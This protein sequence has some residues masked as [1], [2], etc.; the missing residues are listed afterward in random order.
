MADQPLR[1]RGAS[2][3]DP[4]TEPVAPTGPA[5]GPGPSE[6]GPPASDAKHWSERLRVVGGLAAVVVGVIA[7]FG[8]AIGALIANSQ[9]AATIAGSTAGV[10]GSIV[11][12]YFGV[13][14]GTDQAEN[15]LERVEKESATKDKN[16]AKA[17]VYA[18]HVA[19]ADAHAVEAAAEE[20]AGAI[21]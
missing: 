6:N 4:P 13:K 10:V 12:A 1:G 16:A 17:Q 21:R 11:G 3:E 2:G 8:I 20:A 19:S 5:Q 15:A 9:T 7:V 14:L 18:L